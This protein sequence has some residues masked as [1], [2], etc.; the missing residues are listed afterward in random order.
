MFREKEILIQS[1]VSVSPCHRLG[2]SHGHAVMSLL[3]GMGLFLLTSCDDMHAITQGVVTQFT[4]STSDES[5][6]RTVMSGTRVLW[7]Q[8]DAIAVYGNQSSAPATFTLTQGVGTSSAVFSG[9]V[10]QAASYGAVYPATAVTACDLSSSSA[11]FTVTI[12]SQQTATPDSFGPDENVSVA[13][14]TSSALSFRN[15]CGYMG[16]NVTDDDVT[17][18]TITPGS[19]AALTGTATVTCTADGIVDCRSTAGANSVTLQGPLAAGTT[20]YL[21][22]LPGTYSDVE[23]SFQHHDGT[24]TSFTA[25]G[26]ITVS[27]MLRTIIFSGSSAIC[28]VAVKASSAEGGTVSILSGTDSE[29]RCQK[30]TTVTVSATPDEGYDF[31]G[32]LQYDSTYPEGS[33]VSA[34]DTYAFE[35]QDN[36]LLQAVFTPQ[37]NPTLYTVSV[38][39]EN[40]AYGT[41]AIEG[42]EG[43]SGQFTENSPVTLTATPVLGYLFSQW[44]QFV[45]DSWVDIACQDNPFRFLVTADVAYRA[46]FVETTAPDER[47]VL[48]TT[49]K[50]VIEPFG[51]NKQAA[52]N[53]NLYQDMIAPEGGDVYGSTYISFGWRTDFLMA[54]METGG[55]IQEP[56]Y[57]QGQL[58]YWAGYDE[59]CHANNANFSSAFY[60]A[61]DTYPL[62]YVSAQSSPGTPYTHVLRLEKDDSDVNQNENT[63]EYCIDSKQKI[64]F[65]AY[66][67]NEMLYYPDMILDESSNSIWI[68]GYSGNAYLL[69][70]HRPSTMK[71]YQFDLPTPPGQRGGADEVWLTMNDVKTCIDTGELIE[72]AQAAFIKDGYIFQAFGH[73]HH[74]T[75]TTDAS[76]YDEAEDSPNLAKI[77]VISIKEKRVVMELILSDVRDY[78]CPVSHNGTGLPGYSDSHPANEGN[79]EPESLFLY[80]TGDGKGNCLMFLNSDHPYSKHF[81]RITKPT[82][83][84]ILDMVAG[85]KQ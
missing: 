11:T 17:S 26:S 52:W 32:W 68:A 10:E 45:Q 2:I 15:V 42:I 59:N 74:H 34:L 30:G 53:F 40:T 47:I 76:H 70:Q 66:G 23:V 24:T 71:Y 77:V 14:T 48:N 75:S 19:A 21:A 1:P 49:D 44:Q 41:V 83:R 9:E 31:S 69:S 80:D 54:N 38:E 28:T 55:I 56:F 58:D 13:F 60:A 3:A 12:P 78:Y 29:G 73:D 65:P 82:Y 8:G 33:L 6:T 7:S 18:L 20:Y 85:V 84:E 63:D 67:V 37:Y 43:T 57:A 81:I 61:D 36:V 72:T 35:V 4:A 64:H 27:R 50:L 5:S 39:S 16:I 46:V 51:R 62:I 79:F 22:V 25:S